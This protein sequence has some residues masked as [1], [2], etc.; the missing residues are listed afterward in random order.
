[1][2]LSTTVSSVQGMTRTSTVESNIEQV[3]GAAEFGVLLDKGE[4][5]ATFAPQSK[6]SPGIL[7]KNISDMSHESSKK[8][9]NGI[10]DVVF[11]FKG[12]QQQH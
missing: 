12:K 5:Y 1:M 8:Q 4:V 3:Q 11:Y 10:Q 6:L 9:P 7:L 2:A